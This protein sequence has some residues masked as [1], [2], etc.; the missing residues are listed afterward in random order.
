MK[1]H[2]IFVYKIYHMSQNK[3]LNVSLTVI[4]VFVGILFIFSG[5]IKAND[6]SGL[7]YKMGEFFEVWAREDYLPS[8]MH[9]LNNYAMAMSILM[10]TFEIVAGIALIIGYRF[11]LFS[12]LILLVFLGVNLPI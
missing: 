12:F 6:P 8:L 9:W 11:K 5:L 1:E 3:A 4:R 10:I 7:A 2:I